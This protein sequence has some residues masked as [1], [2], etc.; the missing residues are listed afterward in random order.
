MRTRSRS[1]VLR[2]LQFGSF[3]FT[4]F[5]SGVRARDIDVVWATSPPIT[6]AFTA[7]VVARLRRRPFLLE[8]RDLWPDFAVELGVLKEGLLARLARR[9]ERLLYRSADLVVVNSPGFVDHVRERSKNSLD[10][11]VVPNGV[12]VEAFSSSRARDDYRSKMGWSKKIVCIYAG[13][14]GQAND[15]DTLLD[16]AVR[17][18]AHDEILIVLAGD[19]RDRDRIKERI[20]LEEISNVRLVGALPKR[21]VPLL[22]SSGDVGIAI[23]RNIPLFN[24]TYPNKVFDYMAAGLPTVLAID[25]AIR[26]VIEQSS[27]GTFSPPGDSE[28][29]AQVILAYAESD[30]LRALHGANARRFV[31]EH[32]NRADLSEAMLASLEE[33]RERRLARKRARVQN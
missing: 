17:L 14:L 3:M 30:E 23:L 7:L 16:A 11:Q 25:G 2:L 29:L 33:C 31:S 12:E 13:A 4:S 5:W 10:V 18:R 6:Q 28:Q 22:L 26:E 8:I 1:K 15:L 32:F 19:G 21:E 27:G 20:E 24:T 9:V